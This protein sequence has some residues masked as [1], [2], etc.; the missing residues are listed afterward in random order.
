MT[1]QEAKIE[2]ETVNKNESK[3]WETLKE[4]ESAHEKVKAVVEAEHNK[5]LAEWAAHMSRKESLEIFIRMSEGEA[6]S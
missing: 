3:T 4:L 5:R 1:L 6:A 2:L